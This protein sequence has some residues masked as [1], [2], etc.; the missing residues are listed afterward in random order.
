MKL[1][2]NDKYEEVDF[3]SFMKCN[4]LV[5]LALIGLVYGSLFL[6]GLLLYV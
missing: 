2:I 6:L 5:Q 3:W 1:K 4:V